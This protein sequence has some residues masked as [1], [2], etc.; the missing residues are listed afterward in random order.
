MR[1]EAPGGHD[2]VRLVAV[3]DQD[4]EVT[5]DRES[6][7]MRAGQA[8]EHQDVVGSDLADELGMDVDDRRVRCRQGQPQCAEDDDLRVRQRRSGCRA[9]Q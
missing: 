5:G 4:A 2:E 3:G 9:E 8:N 1:V 6:G 7:D